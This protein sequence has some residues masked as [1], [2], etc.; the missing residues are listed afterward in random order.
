MTQESI[1]ELF[2][3]P[4]ILKRQNDT[5][6]A[7]DGYIG[8]VKTFDISRKFSLTRRVFVKECNISCK[9]TFSSYNLDAHA[10]PD[11]QGSGI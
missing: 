9:S 7:M 10:V 1:Q 6:H 11:W 3:L 5:V 8:T 2:N 4:P